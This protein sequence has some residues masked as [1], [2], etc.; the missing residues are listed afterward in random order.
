MLSP[1][2][3]GKTP[4]AE[5][6][7]RK[8]NEIQGERIRASYI[9]S[10]GIALKSCNNN[11]KEIRQAVHTC[12]LST[13]VA[14]NARPTDLPVSFRRDRPG[15]DKR[16]PAARALRYAIRLQCPASE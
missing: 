14:A 16:P 10:V 3:F 4:A 11:L 2:T 12:S 13:K 9:R 15:W 8:L 1:Y 7:V 5:H 6:L